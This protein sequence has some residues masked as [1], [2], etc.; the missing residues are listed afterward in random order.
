MKSSREQNIALLHAARGKDGAEDM[1]HVL[2]EMGRGKSCPPLLR[3]LMFCRAI[4]KYCY[5]F[6]YERNPFA[7]LRLT[8]YADFQSRAT[9]KSTYSVVNAAI[10]LLLERGAALNVVRKAGSSEE[11]VMD[12]ALMYADADVA[13]T[14]RAAGAKYGYELRGDTAEAERRRRI[15][16]THPIDLP[17]PEEW[18][19]V[20]DM[21]EYAR[22]CTALLGLW[23]W[24][25]TLHRGDFMGLYRPL[26]LSLNP[27]YLNRPHLEIRATIIHELAHAMAPQAASHGPIWKLWGAALGQPGMRVPG[28]ALPSPW[29]YSLL[30]TPSRPET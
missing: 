8:S 12:I 28:Y 23:H 25:W 14:L 9:P 5:G 2:T 24:Q 18:H 3:A 20:E 29:V 11:S 19:T 15:D 4:Y 13:Y 6:A 17:E 16:P 26:T 27:D 21:L 22:V 7:P 1:Y 10:L 30:M